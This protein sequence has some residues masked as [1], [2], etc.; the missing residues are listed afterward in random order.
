MSNLPQFAIGDIVQFN[1]GRNQF[2]ITETNQDH[3]YIA[4]LTGNQRTCNAIH[5]SDIHRVGEKSQALDKYG[6]TKEQAA[7]QTFKPGENAIYHI[8]GDIWVKVQSITKGEVLATLGNDT[9]KFIPHLFGGNWRFAE[10]GTG[11]WLRGNT[12]EGFHEF[13]D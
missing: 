3:V 5:V 4:T 8:A 9:K 10:V 2:R 12:G 1:R 13:S 6:R 11:Y 7:E